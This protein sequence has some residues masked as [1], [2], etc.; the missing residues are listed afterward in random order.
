MGP[1][2][3]G[4]IWSGSSQFNGSS[5]EIVIIDA[6]S[7]AVK[8]QFDLGNS[9]VGCFYRHK[10]EMWVGAQDFICAFDVD[11]RS[12]QAAHKTT[13]ATTHCLTISLRQS[14][15]PVRQLRVGIGMID[16]LVGVGDAIWTCSW[17]SSRICVWHAESGAQLHTLTDHTD[18][19][20][21]LVRVGATIWSCSNDRTIMIWDTTVRRW[22]AHTKLALS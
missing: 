19:V 12:C 2:G 13:R 4:D 11:V 17:E 14:H 18:K 16:C 15:Q 21:W 6:K 7:F 22:L 9:G 3:D 10:R 5:G 8:K 1:D 20:R